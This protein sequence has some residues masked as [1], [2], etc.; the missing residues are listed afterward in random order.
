MELRLRGGSVISLSWVPYVSSISCEGMR[1]GGPSW[2]A[3]VVGKLPSLLAPEAG[4]YHG[5]WMIEL[6]PQQFVAA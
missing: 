1:Q 3:G 5:A 2:P 4:D 6:S